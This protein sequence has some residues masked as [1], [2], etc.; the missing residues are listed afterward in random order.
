MALGNDYRVHMLCLGLD[1]QGQI[2]SSRGTKA[3]GSRRHIGGRLKR[4]VTS[5]SVAIFLV[6]A[7]VTGKI[8]FPKPKMVGY[9][10]KYWCWSEIQ[11]QE[12]KHWVSQPKVAI[13]ARMCQIALGLQGYAM[14][15]QSAR[16]GLNC[17]EL[18]KRGGK[19][20]VTKPSPEAFLL[21]PYHMCRQAEAHWRATK[22]SFVLLFN[23]IAKGMRPGFSQ[24][25]LAEYSAP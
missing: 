21:I 9:S 3:I 25:I 2:L 23:S 10:W 13:W 19:T 5:N 24:L 6:S 17:E 7:L 8:V 4:S 22:G 20:R 1:K 11:A 16:P 14:G 18:R 15:L 12:G